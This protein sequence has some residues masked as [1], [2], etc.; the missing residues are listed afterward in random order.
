[1]DCR[2]KNSDVTLPFFFF[3][4]VLVDSRDTDKGVM[5]PPP[6]KGMGSTVGVTAIHSSDGSIKK[7]I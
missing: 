1:M 6:A 3:F 4:N 5:G 2:I 7:L